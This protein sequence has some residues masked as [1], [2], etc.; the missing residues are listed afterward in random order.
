VAAETNMAHSMAPTSQAAPRKSSSVCAC[1]TIIFT[2]CLVLAS[3]TIVGSQLFDGLIA[4]VALGI[5]VTLLLLYCVRAAVRHLF[6]AST[7]GLWLLGAGICCAIYCVIWFVNADRGSNVQIAALLL[8]C[9]S[10]IAWRTLDAESLK[11]QVVSVFVTVLAIISAITLVLWVLGPVTSLVTPNIRVESTWAAVDGMPDG[12]N[13][14]F[15]LL[16][17]TQAFHILG[18]KIIRNSGMFV[19]APMYA[20]VLDIAL[21]VELFVRDGKPRSW[22]IGTLLATILST[23]ST[24]GYLVAILGVALW[25]RLR[26]Q[27]KDRSNHHSNGKVIAVV[28]AIAAISIA[29]LVRKLLSDTGSIRLDDF[30]AGFNSWLESPIVGHG[31]SSDQALR[32]HMSDFRLDSTGFSNSL[33]QVLAFGGVLLLLPYL[34]SFVGLWKSANRRLR[35]F[36]ICIAVAWTFTAVAFLPLSMA[37]LGIGISELLERRTANYH[38]RT[39]PVKGSEADAELMAPKSGCHLSRGM[40]AAALVLSVGVGG[41]VFVASSEFPTCYEETTSIALQRK[42]SGVHV[43]DEKILKGYGSLLSGY[44][45]F[46]SSAKSLG[47]DKAEGYS[48]S[49]TTEEDEGLVISCSADTQQHADEFISALITTAN[50][51][52]AFRSRGLKLVATGTTHVTQIEPCRPLCAIAAAICSLLLLAGIGLLRRPRAVG[53]GR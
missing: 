12:L 20:F 52:P 16:F 42:A 2:L 53:T 22:A 14:Y 47:L 17:E 4:K 28:L 39:A 8:L 48:V 46:L 31:L 44:R 36:G 45:F 43:T 30:V 3:N 34:A 27:E 10:G 6:D 7:L 40:I 21:L 50:S 37:V 19:E 13:G 33:F 9:L 18:L 5:A 49:I 26:M 11:D 1:G 38:A 15:Y 41:I 25:L 24:M 35:S 51:L 32:D 29:L 23:F